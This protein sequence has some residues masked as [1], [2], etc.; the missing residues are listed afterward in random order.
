M[1]R[2]AATTE[3]P[4]KGKRPRKSELKSQYTDAILTELKKIRT[5]LGYPTTAPI[6]PIVH[7][8]EVVK[9]TLLFHGGTKPTVDGPDHW[10]FPDLGTFMHIV[11][12]QNGSF[13]RRIRDS[14]A[15]PFNLLAGNEH[16]VSLIKLRAELTIPSHARPLAPSLHNDGEA[17]IGT[18]DITVPSSPPSPPSQTPSHTQQP[19]PVRLDEEDSDIDISDLC[20]TDRTQPSDATHDDY[21][22]VEVIESLTRFS[23]CNPSS[24]GEAQGV[25]DMI[26]SEQTN[27]FEIDELDSDE[28]ILNSPSIAF[29]RCDISGSSGSASRLS[30]SASRLSGSASRLS[31]SV[32]RSY[33]SAF[34]ITVITWTENDTPAQSVAIE[35]TRNQGPYISLAMISDDLHVLGLTEKGPQLQRFVVDKG[36]MRI[37]WNTL[38][39]I[40][41]T[42]LVVL[43]SVE[44]VDVKD[45]AL[46]L[47]HMYK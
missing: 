4:A 44:V 43:K 3:R 9:K 21:T 34:A 38:F 17:D 37:G 19:N 47:D 46:Q 40:Y 11:A 5:A 8:G 14:R 13:S 27:D 10:K 7:P 29:R 23:S 16:L 36:W 24:T 41:E 32:S 45:W 39:P 25:Q 20:A 15:I 42:K 22:D 2:A 12:K 33:G 30:G 18:G 1:P 6:R 31:G 28:Y 35:L 26:S